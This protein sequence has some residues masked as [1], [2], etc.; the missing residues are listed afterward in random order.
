M[1]VTS[2]VAE[3]TLPLPRDRSAAAAAAGDG[4]VV[5]HAHFGRGEPEAGRVA[6]VAFEVGWDGGDRVAGGSR[7][8]QRWPWPWRRRRVSGGIGQRD[9]VGQRAVRQ[10]ADVDA[11]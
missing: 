4:V 5:G 2:C 6:V 11:A 3:V 10:G 8:V 1:P 9:A 7:L